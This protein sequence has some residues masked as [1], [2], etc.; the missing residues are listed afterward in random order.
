MGLVSSLDIF[1]GLH[2]SL[3]L[4]SLFLSFQG[5]S[6]G[7]ADSKNLAVV[8]YRQVFM[9]EVPV[10]ASGALVLCVESIC[11]VRVAFVSGNVLSVVGIIVPQ[12]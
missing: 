9:V 5:V 8:F 3:I 10:Y 12:V 2:F 4:G 7:L 1:A 11:L 6:A